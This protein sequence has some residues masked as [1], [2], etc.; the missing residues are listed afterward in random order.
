MAQTG[1]RRAAALGRLLA[2]HSGCG[3][4]E[5]GQATCRARLV[6]RPKSRTTRA[7]RQLQVRPWIQ[8]PPRYV[9]LESS[10]WSDAMLRA[11]SLPQRKLPPGEAASAAARRGARARASVQPAAGPRQGGSSG[12]ARDAAGC[13]SCAVRTTRTM[14]TLTQRRSHCASRAACCSTGHVQLGP[15]RHARF[16]ISF[17]SAYY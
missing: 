6:T 15:G 16:Q 8:P 7:T 2:C 14:L 13:G 3:E 11:R 17:E 9:I 12:R 5:R 4:S 10:G 1:R